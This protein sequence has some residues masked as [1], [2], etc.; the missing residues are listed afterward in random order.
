MGTEVEIS[1]DPHVQSEH[2]QEQLNQLAG[3][4]RK[5]VGRVTDVRL[6]AVLETTAEVLIALGTV[7]EHFDSGEE[8]AFARKRRVQSDEL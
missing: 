8:A 5:T 4:A 7:Y 6:K 2:M 1:T 3:H